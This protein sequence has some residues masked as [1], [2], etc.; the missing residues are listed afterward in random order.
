MPVNVL[1]RNGVASDADVVITDISDLDIAPALD[2]LA[3]NGLTVHVVTDG[4]PEEIISAASRATAVIVGYALLDADLIARLPTV[5]IIATMSAGVDMVDIEAAKRSGIW[6]TNVPQAATEE[7]AVH[8]VAGMLSLLR[9][10]PQYSHAAR[11]GQL[12]SASPP[13]PP[14][15]STLTLGLLGLGKIGHRVAQLAGPFFRNVIAHDPW[16]SPETLVDGVELVSLAELAARSNVVSLHSPLTSDN[17]HIVGRDFIDAMPELSYLVNVARGGLVDE[18]AVVRA[19]DS[20]K[21]AGAALDVFER[22][23]L[24]ATNPLLGYPQV[25]TTPHSA[26][27]S[28]QSLEEYVLLP[29]KNI[30]AWRSTGVP[31]TAVSE[32]RK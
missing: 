30:V 23:P 10:L 25:I 3:R 8:A 5:R 18:A 9:C 27:R 24:E 2:L 17:R 28:R 26:Y 16:L 29:A 6:V 7:V 4:N 21:L 32:G 13:A 19:L 15:P 11:V 22:E 12:T 20:G 31:L 1:R 14:R